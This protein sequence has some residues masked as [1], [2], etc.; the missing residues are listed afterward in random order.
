[1]SA[2]AQYA[3]CFGKFI[4]RINVYFHFMQ[5]WFCDTKKNPKTMPQRARFNFDVFLD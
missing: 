3:I 2:F 5:P 4:N 1:M